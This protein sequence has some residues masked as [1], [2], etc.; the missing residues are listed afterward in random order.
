M[1]VKFGSEG[2]IPPTRN[3][4]HRKSTCVKQAAKFTFV[5]SKLG[6]LQSILY[7]PEGKNLLEQAAPF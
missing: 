4:T 3:K 6:T 2:L 7:P 1:S 5:E